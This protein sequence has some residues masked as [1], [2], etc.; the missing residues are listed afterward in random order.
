RDRA[1][2]GTNPSRNC[3]RDQT[4]EDG[5]LKRS[6][7]LLPPIDRRTEKSGMKAWVMSHRGIPKKRGSSYSLA[8]PS[9]SV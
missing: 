4:N 1:T 5:L 3:C 8:P 7:A 2:K 9:K 6:S